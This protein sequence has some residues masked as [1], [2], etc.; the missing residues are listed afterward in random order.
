M[1][2]AITLRGQVQ[3]V[4]G[5]DY[6]AEAA[7]ADADVH[8]LIVPSETKTG[9]TLFDLYTTE[10]QLCFNRRVIMVTAA[11]QAFAQCFIGWQTFD[12]AKEERLVQGGIHHFAHGEDKLALAA[13]N[14]AH[15]LDPANWT[16]MFWIKMVNL[17]HQQSLSDQA[18]ATNASDTITK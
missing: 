10:P 15:D 12:A 11:N 17:V 18:A 1:T 14:A 6:K 8:T 4:G 16:V 5:V 9:K 3:P 13:F 7:F 2:G